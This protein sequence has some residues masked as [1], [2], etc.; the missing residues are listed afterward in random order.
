MD[1]LAEVEGAITIANTVMGNISSMVGQIEGAMTIAQ[2]FVM[3]GEYLAALPIIGIEF[4]GIVDILLGAGSVFIG[5]IESLGFFIPD[6]FDGVLFLFTFA[7]T[8]MMCLF[9]NIANI[10]TCFFYYVLEIIGQILYLPIR[11]FLWVFYQFKIDL[12]PLEKGFWDVIEYLDEIV[13]N[14]LGFHICHYPKNIRE[15]CYNCKRLKI[16]SLVE[17]TGPLATDVSERMPPLLMPGFMQMM[18][19]GQ[20]IMHPF[21]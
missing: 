1:I 8:W 6:F 9:K 12:Y 4:M 16:K 14:Y 19:G 15:L 21:G 18:K 2:G 3:Q 10:Q 5:M 7:I 20:E 11:I 13:M 17:H